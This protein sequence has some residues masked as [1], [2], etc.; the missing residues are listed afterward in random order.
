MAD[1]EI[2]TWCNSPRGPESS[3]KLLLGPLGPQ[4]SHSIL[5]VCEKEDCCSYHL[6]CTF[7]HDSETSGSTVRVTQQ[8]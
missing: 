4:I 7:V 8:R 5:Y 6:P 1:L 3:A 2:S